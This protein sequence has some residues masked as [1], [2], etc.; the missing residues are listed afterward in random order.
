[1]FGEFFSNL[2]FGSDEH[3][4]DTTVDYGLVDETGIVSR[5]ELREAAVYGIEFR[6]CG[7]LRTI[8]GAHKRRRKEPTTGL[9][10]NGLTVRRTKT[11]IEVVVVT[12]EYE[13]IVIDPGY[14]ER[15][16]EDVALSPL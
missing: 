15:I 16:I 8:V 2:L 10:E 12:D 7:Q 9:T 13:R 5:T 4:I 6:F 14:W 11:H 1:M 3:Q